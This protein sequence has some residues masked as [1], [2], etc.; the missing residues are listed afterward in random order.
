MR[1]VSAGYY[2]LEPG[3]PVPCPK[4]ESSGKYLVHGGW[5][6]ARGASIGPQYTMP[7]LNNSYFVENIK[8]VGYSYVLQALRL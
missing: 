7:S 5:Q 2:A 4:G 6:E 8:E 3:P 1:F